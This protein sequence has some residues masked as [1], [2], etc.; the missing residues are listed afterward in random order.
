MSPLTSD[1]LERIEPDPRSKGSVRLIIGGRTALTVPLDAVAAEQLAPG[2]PLDEPLRARLTAWADEDAAFRTALRSLE[3][4]AFARRDL[5]KR[6]RLKGHA[7]PAVDAA[8]A[9]AERLGYLDDERFAR[10]YVQSRTARGRGPARIRRELWAQGVSSAV[11]DRILA[12]E[13]PEGADNDRIVELA[14]KRAGQLQSLERQ[15][16]FRRV[17]AF[18]ARRGY[19]GSEVR[20]LVREAI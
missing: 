13:V 19:T 20:R 9:R 14:R 11:A 3:R 12:E 18:L 7:Q 17:V 15:D 2:V 5:S 16:R 4:R 1:V 6:L 10:H 8:L